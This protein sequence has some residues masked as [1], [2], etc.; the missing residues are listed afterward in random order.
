VNVVI[1]DDE[2]LARAELRRLLGRLPGVGATVVGEAAN[3]DEAERV[4]AGVR[5]D[6]LLLD[7]EM[8]GASGFDLLERLPHVPPVIFTTAYDRHAVRAFEVSALD[9]LLKPIELDRLATALARVGDRARP[10]V[11][12]R[13]GAR[14]WLVPLD[15]V[16][17]VVSD[18]NYVRLVWGERELLLAR[19]LAALESHLDPR[20]FVRANRAELVNLGLVDRVTPEPNGTLVVALRGGG[21]VVV[22][23]RQ[24]RRLRSTL[25]M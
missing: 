14:C 13:D 18:G 4:L 5:A 25:G 17:L 24:A 10:R 3:A 16:R 8:P 15:E 23:R 6:V 1:V 21:T 9:Y 2:P 20:V 7:I 12:V 22:S 19:S 11:F